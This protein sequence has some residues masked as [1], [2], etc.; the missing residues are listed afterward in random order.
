MAHLLLSSHASLLKL[1]LLL[2]ALLARPGPSFMAISSSFSPLF[3]WAFS[4]HFSLVAS[5]LS[6]V[7]VFSSVLFVCYSI[8]L[9]L[10]TYVSIF[11]KCS[12][13]S[14]SF[15]LM[16]FSDQLSEQNIENIL[17]CCV[18]YYFPKHDMNTLILKDWLLRGH[19]LDVKHLKQKPNFQLNLFLNIH[20]LSTVCFI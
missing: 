15:I 12:G 3:K 16:P 6:L 11:F 2:L 5:L 9:Y 14:A 7:S 8:Y 10:Y 1:S 20:M 19:L 4:H 18:F 13:P 17:P